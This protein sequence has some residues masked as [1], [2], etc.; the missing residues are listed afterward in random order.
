MIDGPR[1]PK[2]MVSVSDEVRFHDA[3]FPPTTAGR[4]RSPTRPQHRATGGGDDPRRL[5]RRRPDVDGHVVTIGIEPTEGGVLEVRRGAAVDAH[6]PAHQDRVIVTKEQRMPA[7]PGRG[8]GGKGDVAHSAAVET[9]IERPG[10]RQ[11]SEAGVLAR[12]ATGEHMPRVG[13]RCSVA[14]GNVTAC[15]PRSRL[16]PLPMLVSRTPRSVKRAIPSHHPLAL[17]AVP[18]HT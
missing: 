4:G 8:R 10:Q 2:A 17:S 15:L 12:S 14:C 3:A 11:R 18:I 7:L 6:A 9:R 13:I 5:R 1:D 16:P